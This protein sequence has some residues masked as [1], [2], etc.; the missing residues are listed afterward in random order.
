M[1]Q[2][3]RHRLAGASAQDLTRLKSKNRLTASSS[4][5]LDSLPG[6]LKALAGFISL[7]FLASCRT[8]AIHNSYRSLPGPGH[9]AL[10]TTYI[11]P[12]PA[13]DLSPGTAQFIF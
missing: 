7:C 5:I 8:G 12:R 2:E 1:G 9:V 10:S 3:F 4:G 13:G 11:A 6:S